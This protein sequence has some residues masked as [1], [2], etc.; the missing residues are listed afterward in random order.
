MVKDLIDIEFEADTLNEAVEKALSEF[1]CSRAETD[2]EIL[3]VPSSRFFGL[4]GVK[5]AK[6]RVRVHDRGIVARR[7]TEKMLAV[8]GFSAEVTLRSERKT[9]YIDLRSEESKLL[10]GRHG[11]T[12]NG[13]QTLVVALG[14]HLDAGTDRNAP[15]TPRKRTRKRDA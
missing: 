12:L 2:V 9:F 8:A 15:S 10:I 11:Q 3:Q 1:G 7:I 5:P 14:H 6:V 4:F 13:F